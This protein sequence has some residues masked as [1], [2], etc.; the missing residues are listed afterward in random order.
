MEYSPPFVQD[1]ELMDSV[2][3]FLSKRPCIFDYESPTKHPKKCIFLVTGP[4]HSISSYDSTSMIPLN[5]LIPQVSYKQLKIMFLTSKPYFLSC[6]N[7]LCTEID[8]TIKLPFSLAE[9]LLEKS[10]AMLKKTLIKSPRCFLESSEDKKNYINARKNAHSA[11]EVLYPYLLKSFTILN[12]KRSETSKTTKTVEYRPKQLKIIMAFYFARFLLTEMHMGN[13]LDISELH[14]IMH[15][16]DIKNLF[17]S[18]ESFAPSSRAFILE[19]WISF[20]YI[21]KDVNYRK[22]IIELNNSFASWIKPNQLS[23]VFHKNVEFFHRIL[24]KPIIRGTYDKTLNNPNYE[25]IVRDMLK[26]VVFAYFHGHSSF[27]GFTKMIYISAKDLDDMYLFNK[28]LWKA[29]LLVCLIHEMA[30]YYRGYF[31]TNDKEWVENVTLEVRYCKK[32]YECEKSLFGGKVQNIYK[33]IARFLNKEVSWDLD[34]ESFKENF[35]RIYKYCR[36]NEEQYVI[37]Y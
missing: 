18:L 26:N 22:D 32:V 8:P 23:E 21:G 25:G 10:A 13:Q 1:Q 11:L 35:M 6:S 16:V 14:P 34:C 17:L 29:Y 3:P 36:D 5:S 20:F 9:N 4:Y 19:H 2:G 7:C 27:A 24:L 33:N 37:F 31:L 15:F 28:D 30:N 12:S